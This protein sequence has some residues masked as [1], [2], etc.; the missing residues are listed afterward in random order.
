MTAVAKPK[1]S[2]GYASERVF[3]GVRVVDD[4]RVVAR[5]AELGRKAL[6]AARKKPEAK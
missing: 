3:N 4:P 2:D 6:A 5:L 1:P